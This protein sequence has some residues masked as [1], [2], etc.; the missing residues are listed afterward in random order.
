[1]E[2]FHFAL[3]ISGR[4]I[5]FL[6]NPLKFKSFQLQKCINPYNT[7]KDS[8]SSSLLRVSLVNCCSLSSRNVK[9]RRSLATL[10]RPLKILIGELHWWYLL[11]SSFIFSSD[12]DNMINW[13]A[14]GIKWLQGA[15]SFCKFFSFHFSFWL[16]RVGRKVIQGVNLTFLSLI[17]SDETRSDLTKIS[18]LEHKFQDCIFFSKSSYQTCHFK[19]FLVLH[20]FQ[21]WKF[22]R[23]NSASSYWT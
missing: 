6:L 20:F 1:M 14:P 18:G 23:Y 21:F 17:K 4:N 3:N 7:T 2:V 19:M 15:L 11:P 9:V 13:E 10:Q 12:I 8:L 5:L 16:V 22:K